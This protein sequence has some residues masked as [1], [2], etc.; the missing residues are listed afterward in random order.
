VTDFDPLARVRSSF[1][2]Q[3]LM[4]HLGARLGTVEPGITRIL[5]PARPER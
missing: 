1:D 5:L 2:R 4:V 3:R